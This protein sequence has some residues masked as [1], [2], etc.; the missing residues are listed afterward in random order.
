MSVWSIIRLIWLIG[1]LILI[2]PAARAMLRGSQ[3]K[4]L[5]LVLWLG[6]VVA[7]A[8][9]YQMFHGDRFDERPAPRPS[10]GAETVAA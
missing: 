1:A 9:G 6:I 2:A 4:M 10:P 3:S 5:H 7:L 8:A